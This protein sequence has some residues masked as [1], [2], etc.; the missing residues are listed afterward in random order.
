MGDFKSSTKDTKTIQWHDLST[1]PQNKVTLVIPVK[2]GIQKNCLDTGFH[3][4]HEP[5]VDTYLC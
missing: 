4:Y 5:R 2:T 3:R 1:A